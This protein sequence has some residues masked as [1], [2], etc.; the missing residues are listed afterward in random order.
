MTKT[1][2]PSYAYMLK[3]ETTLS[4]HW[5]K[6]WPDYHID[7]SDTVVKGGGHLSHCH[8]MFG[9]VVAWLY[10]RVAGLDLSTVYQGTIRFAPR[11]TKQLNTASATVE[12]P[13]G[14]A[15]I[16]W[17]QEGD[18]SAEMQIPNGLKGVLELRTDETLYVETVRGQTQKYVP[19]DGKVEI[20]LHSG[21]VCVVAKNEKE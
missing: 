17:R 12:T 18:F 14:K 7:N 19:K 11:F 9:S 4:E 6:R 5:S 16:S 13:F 21:K 20:L 15:S 8:P 1:D 2:Y 3:G 10:K